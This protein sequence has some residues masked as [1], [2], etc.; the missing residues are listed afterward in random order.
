[1]ARQPFGLAD[2]VIGGG[3]LLLGMGY[4]L[5]RGLAI[6]AVW[7]LLVTLIVSYGFRMPATAGVIIALV[8]VFVVAQMGRRFILERFEN[9]S[10]SEEATERKKKDPAPHSSDP[11][12]DAGTTILHAY[13]KLDPEQVVQM[14]KDTQ[15]LMDTQKQLI[16]T[17]A[18]L[19]PQVQ[20]GAELIETF[21]KTFGG[22][23]LSQAGS[24]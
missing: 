19:G 15:D 21:K 18:S 24:S 7:L 17:L 1:M 23:L 12:L 6:L 22:N 4:L 9:E 14:R 5:S 10:A 2:L 11:H 3:G 16:E 20:Q 8:V 13:R